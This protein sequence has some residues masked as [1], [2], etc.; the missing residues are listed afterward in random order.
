MDRPWGGAWKS[1]PELRARAPRHGLPLAAA[2]TIGRVSSGWVNLL[3]RLPRDALLLASDNGRSRF[4][5]RNPSGGA[6]SPRS[7]LRTM[8]V[9]FCGHVHGRWRLS[10]SLNPPPSCRAR[11]GQWPT[12]NRTRARRRSPPRVPTPPRTS[13]GRDSR[14]PMRGIT[15]RIVLTAPIS[16]NNIRIIDISIRSSGASS[17][18]TSSGAMNTRI[19]RSSK[20]RFGSGET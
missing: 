1:A 15:M 12:Q 10:P 16:R 6:L 18:N 13:E 19:T 8:R 14:L 5:G 7:A 9:A 17:S 11:Q 20:L 4:L 2:A 3:D